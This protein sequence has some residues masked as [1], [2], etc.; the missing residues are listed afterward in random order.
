MVYKPTLFNRIVVLF[1]MANSLAPLV[2]AQGRGQSVPAASA[3]P[4]CAITEP[5]RAEPRKD[6]NADRFGFGPW[7]VNADHTIWA[8]WD[9]GK[10]VSGRKGN[11]V[12]WI[13]PQGTQLRVKGRR[14]DANSAPLKARVP[15]CYPTG[16]QVTGLIFPTIGCWQVTATAGASTL[17]FVTSI[18]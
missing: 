18:Q 2:L 4:A 6:P 11:K 14:L 7:Y 10:W 3:M 8:G 5:V 16:F 15:C 1:A 17:T 9:L 12:M 13:R